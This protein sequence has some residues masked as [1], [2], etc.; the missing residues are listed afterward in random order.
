MTTFF[1]VRHAEKTDAANLLSGRRPGVS[2]TVRGRE[3]AVRL[4]RHFASLAPPPGAIYSSP[5]ERA[6]E[7]ACAIGEACGL[8]VQCD[9]RLH[10]F[11]FGEWTGRTFAE[12]RSDSRWSAF[13]ERRS[14]VG[15]PGGETMLAVQHRFVEALLALTKRELGRAVVV[16][17]PDS[18]SILAPFP[19]CDSTRAV[20]RS[21]RSTPP[22]DRLRVT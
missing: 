11:D 10:E 2:L 4:G 17:S 1:L 13:N 20:R 16:V 3:Q 8:A 6:Q 5:L 21:S 12:L 9:E 19:R 22:F 18:P 14:L 15:A 7:T